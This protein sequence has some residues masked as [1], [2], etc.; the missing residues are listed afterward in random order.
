MVQ[1]QP[2]QRIRWTEI[3]DEE[4][5]RLA[6]RLVITVPMPRA[7]ELYFEGCGM[8]DSHNF[9]RKMCGIEKRVRTQSWSTRVNLGIVAMMFVDAF[10]LYKACCGKSAKLDPK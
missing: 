4:G 8:I 3:G 2:Y 1:G 5:E 9:I 6:K 10:L 7:S